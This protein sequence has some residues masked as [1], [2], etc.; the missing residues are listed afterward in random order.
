M[1]TVRHLARRYLPPATPH[2]ANKAAAPT[3]TCRPYPRHCV[4]KKQ[5]PFSPSPSRLPLL[6]THLAL[7]MP[8]LLLTPAPPMSTAASSSSELS[9]IV[10][11][12]AEDHPMSLA[13]KIQ[14]PA[15]TTA[16]VASSVA[17]ASEHGLPQL[18]PPHHPLVLQ[19]PS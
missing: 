10:S 19:P 12:R 2:A 17:F 1:V 7:L 8:S 16:A 11:H 3:C 15:A 6:N 13:A 18:P 14:T 5:I 9:L 4:E